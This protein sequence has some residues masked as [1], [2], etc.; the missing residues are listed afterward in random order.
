MCAVS[1][2]LVL[3]PIWTQPISELW[4]VKKQQQQRNLWREF[5][6]FCENSQSRNIP[7][8]N[9]KFTLTIYRKAYT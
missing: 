9:V 4:I 8:S 6:T 7:D 1:I 2:A 5:L 3:L